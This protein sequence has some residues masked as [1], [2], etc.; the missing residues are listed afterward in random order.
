MRSC[1]RFAPR[2]TRSANDQTR[3]VPFH[4]LRSCDSS[5]SRERST[6]C[7]RRRQA[8]RDGQQ[9]VER[10]AS[11]VGEADKDER[12][13]AVEVGRVVGVGR[14]FDQKVPFV[15]SV[16]DNSPAALAGMRAGDVVI[17]ADSKPVATTN[18]WAKAVKN[19]HGHP[20]SITVMRDKKEQTLTL[21]PDGKKRL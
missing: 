21:T 17:R 2:S 12:I 8:V 1:S 18:D 4:A 15:R 16:I 14:V 7:L 9:I 19:S 13:R 3:A 6:S 20:L 5:D 11:D 10:V